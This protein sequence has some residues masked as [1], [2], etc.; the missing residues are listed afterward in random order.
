MGV[1]RRSRAGRRLVCPDCYCLLSREVTSQIRRAGWRQP[2]AGSRRMK[3]MSSVRRRYNKEEFAHRGD[4][5]YERAVHPLLKRE[6][7]GKFVALDI[8]TSEFEIDDD[9]LTAC[10]RLRARLP[11]A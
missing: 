8:E 6:D 5:I 10:D 3:I 7:N 1:H 4:T 11:E 9:E 2:L